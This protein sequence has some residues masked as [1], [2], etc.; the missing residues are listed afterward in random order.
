[1]L[2]G[3]PTVFPMADARVGVAIGSP[4]VGDD[5]VAGP[6]VAPGFALGRD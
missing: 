3:G 5:D 2:E 6:G 4:G 1:M